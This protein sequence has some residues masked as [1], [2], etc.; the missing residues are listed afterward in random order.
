MN[1]A[2]EA[3]ITSSEKITVIHFWATW[4]GPCI[5]ELPALIN[6]LPEFKKYDVQT[7]IISTDSAG[8]TKVPAFLKQQKIEISD[9]YLDPKSTYFKRIFGNT[10]PTT[11]LV[12]RNGNEIGRVNG[13]TKWTKNSVAYLLSRVTSP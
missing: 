6:I 2:S 10:L 12:D 1:S 11:I 3:L 9:L 4:C 5:Q 13:A 8:L 7:Y